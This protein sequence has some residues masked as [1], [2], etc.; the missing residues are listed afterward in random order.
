MVSVTQDTQRETIPTL[1]VSDI[2]PA[3]E[4]LI[5]RY[6]FRL[7][8]IVPAD[9]PQSAIVSNNGKLLRLESARM[10]KAGIGQDQIDARPLLFSR[11]NGT[12]QWHQG[13]AGMEYR[14][15][16]PGRMNGECIASHIR[17]ANGGPTPDYVH[18]HKVSFQV[19]F[20]RSGWARLVYQD[21]GPPFVLEPGDCV[22]QPP[23][24]R[25]RVLETSPGFEVIEV[26]SPAVHETWVDH[27]L[28]LPENETTTED[29]SRSHPDNRRIDSGQP[30]LW[31]RAS[32]ATWKR[33]PHGL[34]LQETGIEV[35]TGGLG[36]VRVLRWNTAAAFRDSLKHQSQLLFVLAGKLNIDGPERALVELSAGDSVAIRAA[37]G[38]RLHSHAG[39]EL[40]QVGLPRSVNLA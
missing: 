22:L 13:R 36:S 8:M 12:G 11:L 29:T 9:E 40:L 15:L 39:L 31:H 34:E 37:A 23:E 18:Y 28:L 30:F 5:T 2:G 10:A 24:I 26:G 16:I 17:I 6:G 14:D 7:E 19:I 3:I 25:H 35:A 20:C 27:D 1:Q 21:Q 33:N 32:E 4:I 38:L